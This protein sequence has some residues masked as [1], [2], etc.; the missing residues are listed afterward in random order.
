M[1]CNI[2]HCSKECVT[3]PQCHILHQLV[4]QAQFIFYSEVL[5]LCGWDQTIII[6][7]IAVWEISVAFKLRVNY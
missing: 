3:L 2:W 4:W 5:C 1:G 6:V 7:V